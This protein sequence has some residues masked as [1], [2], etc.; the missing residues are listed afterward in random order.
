MLVRTAPRVP[1]ASARWGWLLVT[2][3][4]DPASPRS[5]P[6]HGA[7]SGCKGSLWKLGLTWGKL[8]ARA[9]NSDWRVRWTHPILGGIAVWLCT[10]GTYLHSNHRQHLHRDAIEFIETAPGSGLSQPFVDVATG[11]EIK[12]KGRGFRDTEPPQE[13]F[14]LGICY[15]AQLLGAARL[16]CFVKWPPAPPGQP[17]SSCLDPN[18]SLAAEPGERRPRAQPGFRHQRGALQL[19]A[20]GVLQGCLPKVSPHPAGRL[21]PAWHHRLLPAALPCSPS[22][23]SS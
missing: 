9:G 4:R 5:P 20:G 16:L 22:A 6:Q 23:R 12:A 3:P 13:G 1:A 11:L 19:E 10:E 21:S 14:S 15:E 8:S 7:G 17:G 2:V 18:P